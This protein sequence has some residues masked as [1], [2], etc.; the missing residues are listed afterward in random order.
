MLTVILSFTT[1]SKRHGIYVIYFIQEFNFLKVSNE[2]LMA[3][4]NKELLQWHE[5]EE[6]MKVHFTITD[7]GPGKSKSRPGSGPT[8]LKSIESSR[9]LNRSDSDLR[10]YEALPSIG[11]TSNDGSNKSSPPPMPPDPFAVHLSATARTHPI[12]EFCTKFIHIADRFFIRG[13]FP[14]LLFQAYF[15]VFQ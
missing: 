2:T 15:G 5:N 6:K 14:F 10:K 9:Q 12:E 1:L 7:S 11:M 3:K 13:Y 8:K 4:Y